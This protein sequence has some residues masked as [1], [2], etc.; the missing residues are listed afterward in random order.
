M[1]LASYNNVGINWNSKTRGAPQRLRG[2]V[3]KPPYFQARAG[4]LGVRDFILRAILT[5]GGG[6]AAR[7]WPM[8]R[9]LPIASVH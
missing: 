9:R 1:L 3:A 8:A 7:R 5:R 6:A 2:R 4:P